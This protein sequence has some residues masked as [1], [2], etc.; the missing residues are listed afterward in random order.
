[1]TSWAVPDLWY[2]YFQNNHQQPPTTIHK[3]LKPC[4]SIWNHLQ[5]PTT[6]HNHSQ[7]PTAVHKHPQL[8]RKVKTCHKVSLWF[9]RSHYNRVYIW[10][11]HVFLCA[12][13]CMCVCAFISFPRRGFSWLKQRN[14]CNAKDQASDV[15]LRELLCTFIA[16]S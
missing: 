7:P 8:P 3:H 2:M 14:K 5:P 10:Y 11:W 6:I 16:T 4:W 1:M 9:C 13:V 15:V 12:C